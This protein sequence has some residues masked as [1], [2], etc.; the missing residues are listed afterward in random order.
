MTETITDRPRLGE[1]F[2]RRL[3]PGHYRRVQL[4]LDGAIATVCLSNPT[5]RNAVD[6]HMHD[7]IADVFAAIH[8]ESAVRAVIL[9]GDPAGGA[10]CAGGDLDWLRDQAPTG[11]GYE[12]ILR[13]GIDLVRAMLNVRQPVVAQVNGTA[14]GLG[15]TLALLADVVYVGEQVTFADPHVGIGVVAGDGGAAL[16]P[17][18]VGPHRAKEFLMTGDRLTGARAAE[19]GLVNHALP[20]DDVEEAAR[21]M[22]LRLAEGPRLAVEMTKASVNLLLRQSIEQ[23]LTASIAMEGLSFHS[24]D[25]REA[26]RAFGVKQAPRWGAT[27][28]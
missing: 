18:L 19:M 9:T 15:A 17:L 1:G 16:W 3:E 28:N 20:A 24:S 11:E 23:V 4:R 6:G 5:R 7:E 27:E 13:G 12:V 21:A 26:L 22:A 14:I 2:A 8:R 25:H 10:F